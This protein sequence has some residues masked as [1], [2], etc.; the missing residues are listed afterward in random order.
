MKLKLMPKISTIL[1]Q[2]VCMKDYIDKY[3]KMEI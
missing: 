1:E 3:E 2:S